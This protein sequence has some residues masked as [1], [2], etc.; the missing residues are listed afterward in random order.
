MP[1]E[2]PLEQWRHI[3]DPAREG[4]WRA[5]DG[6]AI[7]RIDLVN[8]GAP[9]RGS[10]L[11]LPGRGDAYEK[12]LE[13]L[14]HWHGQ[15]WNVAAFDWRGQAGSGRFG[16]AENV[17]HI[18]D[19]AT[20]VDDLAELWAPWCAATPGPH[21]LVGHSMGGHLALRALA[22]KKID[23]AVL[24]LSAPMLGLHLLGLPTRVLHWIA[25][26]FCA[27]GDRRRPAW[28]SSEKPGSGESLRMMLL[29]HDERRYADDAY[30]REARPELAMGPASWG[31]I[32]RAIASIRGL[33]AP[34]VIEAVRTPVLLLAARQD[35]LV[36]TPAIARMA[37]RLPQGEYHVF[38]GRHELL[39]EADPLRDRVLAAIDAFLDQETR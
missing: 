13:T 18:D 27:I 29:T 5:A 3:P 23:P 22:E 36:D 39:R 8:A 9:S 25:R 21:V 4:Q 17:G 32:E 30:W 19:F 16:L 14:V 38:D 15:G 35:R 26:S 20:W 37:A 2:Y 31:W 1:A 24:V 7:R 33:E 34:G 12:W 11:F 28:S 10:L 6:T